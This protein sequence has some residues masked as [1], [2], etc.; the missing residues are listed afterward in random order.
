VERIDEDSGPARQK[1]KAGAWLTQSS[2]RARPVI[3]PN[4]RLQLRELKIDDIEL[5]T[6]RPRT[7]A[8][9]ARIDLAVESAGKLH[10]KANHGLRAHLEGHPFESPR[11]GGGLWL[12]D[13]FDREVAAN[14]RRHPG[15]S[16]FGIRLIAAMSPASPR[17]A[18]M[19][20]LAVLRSIF[21]STLK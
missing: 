3:S 16:R 15:W 21:S 17:T 18:K 10:S 2:W 19:E 6:G 7:E 8:Y 12:E 4:C 1:E 5:E 9:I 13:F 11:V 14:E 20:G